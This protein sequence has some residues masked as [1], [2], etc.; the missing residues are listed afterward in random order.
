MII[1]EFLC[2]LSI[3]I[4]RLFFLIFLRCVVGVWSFINNHKWCFFYAVKFHI[5]LK[6]FTQNKV[7]LNDFRSWSSL[8]NSVVCQLHSPLFLSSPD[9]KLNVLTILIVNIGKFFSQIQWSSQNI[10]ERKRIKISVQ[11][12]SYCV[13]GTTLNCRHEGSF[14]S[15]CSNLFLGPMCL[16]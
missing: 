16:M 9:I 10:I 3:L 7:L 12:L 4:L 11:A 6:V 2:I 1:Y 8:S 13:N 14:S 15:N 5:I